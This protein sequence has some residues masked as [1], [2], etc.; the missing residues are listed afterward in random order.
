MIIAQITGGLGNQMFQYAAAKALS[1]HL[2]SPLKLDLQSY[3]REILPELEV[4]R[5]FELTSFQNF[6]YKEASIEEI[7][8]FTTSNFFSRKIKHFLPF[9]M[10]KV[11]S[12][13]NNTFDNN[14]FK[15]GKSAYLKGHRQTEKYFKG[16]Q[17]EIKNSYQLKNDLITDVKELGKLISSQSSVSVHIRRGDY[18]RLPI[19]LDWHGV[20]G[21][22]YYTKALETIQSKFP[23]INIYYFSDDVEWVEKELLPIFPGTILSGTIAS[24]HYHDFYLMQCC[25]NNVVANSSF[26]WWSAWL[27]QHPDKMI[28][29]PRKWFGN[30]RLSTKDLYPKDWIVL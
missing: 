13:K 4:F 17:N 18:L 15:A 30:P 8:A 16:Y 24:T 14:F 1:I 26:S 28:I 29:A 21:F 10:R 6:E 27:N 5:S 11:F 2:N 7:N 19:I 9:H 3:K 12:E 22:D 25:R 23:N 20:L